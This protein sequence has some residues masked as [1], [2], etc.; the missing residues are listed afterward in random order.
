LLEIEGIK[1]EAQDS[2]F[3]ETVEIESFSF[4]A[5]HPGSFAIGTGGGTGK[6]NMQDV[7]LS[8]K[9]SK[10]SPNLFQACASG[11]HINKATLHVR[12]ATGDGGQQE[13]MTL[14]LEHIL[15]SSYQSGGHAGDSNTETLPTEQFSLNF[16]IVKFEYKPQDNTGK[17]G[18]AV[19][20]KWD[21]Q[22]NM[23]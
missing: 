18:A 10:A 6:V 23:A 14:N 3:N 15:V 1:G 16:A 19:T 7:H 2:K 17:L 12:K 11:K 4:G 13:Y 9:V 22:K 20:G 8:T 5:S 21:L